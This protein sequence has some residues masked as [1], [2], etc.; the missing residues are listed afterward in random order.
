MELGNML[1]PKDVPAAAAKREDENL[2]FRTFLKIHADPDELDQQFLA[3]HRE[4][5]AEYD[6]CQCGNCCRRYSTTLSE[7]EIADISAYLGVTRQKFLED[8]LIRGR[9][10]LELPAPCRFLDM[11]GRCRIQDCKPE[12]CRSFPYTDRPDRLA[13]M[14]SILSAAEVCPVVFEILERLKELYHF[15]KRRR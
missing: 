10:G 8:C 7:D 2:R 5:F 11:D 13:S 3:L 9:D 4:L 12:E 15:G 1:A 6:C 14:Y